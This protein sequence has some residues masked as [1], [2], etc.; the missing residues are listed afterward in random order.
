MHD[1]VVGVPYTNCSYES[2]VACTR[3]DEA[4]A[5]AF[6]AYLMGK[7]PLVFMQNSGIGS[8]VDFIT[9][10]LKPAEV[11]IPLVIQHRDSPEQHKEMGLIWKPLMALMEYDNYEEV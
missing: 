7:K 5:M 6:G 9:S 1:F 8:C 10:I 3:E 2:A 11:S 4:L